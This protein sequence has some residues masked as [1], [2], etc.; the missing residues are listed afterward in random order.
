MT[1][2]QYRYKKYKSLNRCVR[3][4]K[5]DELTLN[6]RSLCFECNEKNKVRVRK[7]YEQNKEK[8][9]AAIMEDRQRLL[10]KGIC[11]DCRKKAAAKGRQRCKEC[12]NKRLE[13]TRK[14]QQKRRLEEIEGVK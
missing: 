4:G 13:A 2:A 9:K 14:W 7:Y 5:Q 11:I 12:L 1:Q 3:C 10:K 8:K 6:E